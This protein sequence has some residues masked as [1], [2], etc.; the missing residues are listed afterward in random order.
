[1]S[2]FKDFVRQARELQKRA[3]ADI[4]YVSTPNGDE[5]P[6]RS[7]FSPNLASTHAKPYITPKGDLIISFDNDSKYHWWRGGQSVLR[8]LV[9]LGA[10]EDILDRYVANWR[11][12]LSEEQLN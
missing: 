8:T 3:D 6:N 11:L 7:Q 10:R 1:M 4:S 9:E 2:S 12:K 5:S